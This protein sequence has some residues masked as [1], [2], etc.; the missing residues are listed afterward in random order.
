MTK[1]TSLTVTAVTRLI[2][3]A[4]HALIGAKFSRELSDPEKQALAACTAYMEMAT[5]APATGLLRM[6]EQLREMNRVSR[7]IDRLL[8]PTRRGRVTRRAQ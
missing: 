1:R 7:K 4:R 6:A 8:A 3:S 5:A 2:N